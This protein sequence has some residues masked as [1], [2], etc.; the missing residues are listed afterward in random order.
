MNKRCLIYLSGVY[1]I[2]LFDLRCTIPIPFYDTFGRYL[3]KVSAI[4]D[5]YDTFITI[6]TI[7]LSRFLRYFYHDTYDTLADSTSKNGRNPP[8]SHF[9]PIGPE[10][11]QNFWDQSDQS[12][13]SGTV[14][15]YYGKRWNM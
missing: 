15:S 12:G 1:T 6:L 4:P 13:R 9:V 11:S 10:W 2:P 8:M 5:N 3:V 7:L 14:T